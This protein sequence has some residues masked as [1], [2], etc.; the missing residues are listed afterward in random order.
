MDERSRENLATCDPKLQTIF[1]AVDRF[2]PLRVIEGHRSPERQ[3]QL[4]NE[5]RSKVKVG[6]HNT[7]PSRAA[8]VAS[9]PINWKDKDKFYYFAG[10]VIGMGAAM[11]YKL[12]WG[13]DWD[14]DHELNDQTFMDLVHFEI[15]E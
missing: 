7:T 12:R 14:Q 15:V 13:G 4:F 5:G 2:I 8:D 3:I 11:G 9:L 6:E 10:F 1:G